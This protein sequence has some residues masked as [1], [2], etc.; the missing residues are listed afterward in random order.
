MSLLLS[1]SVTLVV[2]P[3]SAALYSSQQIQ[4]AFPELLLMAERVWEARGG[5]VTHLVC[6]SLGF[7]NRELL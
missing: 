2:E 6:C 4:S 3:G 7:A 1:Q 5:Q